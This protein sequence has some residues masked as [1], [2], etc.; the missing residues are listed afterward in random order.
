M[1]IFN[2]IILLI[3][4]VNVYAS[5][6]NKTPKEII[7]V[8]AGAAD[9][10]Y[11]HKNECIPKMKNDDNNDN[12]NLDPI[13]IN[14]GDIGYS[15]IKG[16]IY[17]IIPELRKLNKEDAKDFFSKELFPIIKKLL[18][19]NGIE[20][21]NNINE[22]T[23]KL[24]KS[25]IN[26]YL[27]EKDIIRELLSS[28]NDLITPPSLFTDDYIKK[29][30]LY[31]HIKNSDNKNKNQ[32]LKKIIDFVNND[33]SKF[34]DI[35]RMKSQYK[36]KNDENTKPEDVIDPEDLEHIFDL[37]KGDKICKKYFENHNNS[38]LQFSIFKSTINNIDRYHLLLNDSKNNKIIHPITIKVSKDNKYL[39]NKKDYDID[40]D[41]FPKEIYFYNPIN[42][43]K[44][45]LNSYVDEVY[46]LLSD[47]E[48]NI[49]NKSL[50]ILNKVVKNLSKGDIPKNVID[51]LDKQLIPV[52]LD[53]YN[54]LDDYF[55][56]STNEQKVRLTRKIIENIKDLFVEEKRKLRFSYHTV[57][58]F[59]ANDIKNKL[60]KIFKDEKNE[61]LIQNSSFDFNLIKRAISDNSNFTLKELEQLESM[62]KIYTKA[63]TDE[64]DNYYKVIF[65][66]LFNYYHLV[67]EEKITLNFKDETGYD[68]LKDYLIKVLNHDYLNTDFI[69]NAF[70]FC[71]NDINKKNIESIHKYFGSK[72]YNII[73]LDNGYLEDNS[74]EILIKSGSVLRDMNEYSKIFI[75]QVKDIDLGDYIKE[76]EIKGYQYIDRDKNDISVNKVNNNGVGKYLL[77]QDS[78]GNNVLE[79]IIDI[80]TDDQKNTNLPSQLEELYN[81][82]IKDNTIQNNDDNNNDDNNNNYDSNNNDNG[83]K[84]KIDDADDDDD[85]SD[86]GKKRKIG[87][88]NN[89]DNDSSNNDNIRKRKIHD[90]KN[91]NHWIDDILQY[92]IVDIFNNAYGNYLNI[93]KIK[94]QLNTYDDPTENINIEELAEEIANNFVVQ[95]NYFPDDV[96]IKKGI[97]LKNDPDNFNYVNLKKNI[98]DYLK[99]QDYEKIN[100]IKLLLD[101]AITQSFS[102]CIKANK[103]INYFKDINDD[104]DEDEELSLKKQ[105][106]Y[107]N[108][109][110]TKSEILDLKKIKDNYNHD[111]INFF[112]NIVNNNLGSHFYNLNTLTKN[113]YNRDITGNDINK[114]VF[115]NTGIFIVG[116]NIFEMYF[117]TNKDSTINGL[118]ADI[119]HVAYIDGKLKTLEV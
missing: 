63:N 84:R 16:T 61:Y 92:S 45:E 40:Y 7:A 78:D 108:N 87:D 66:D 49:I 98:I 31:P 77:G 52:H 83:K 102:T 101:N 103:I 75:P 74:L 64:L 90:F 18:K 119:N 22:D 36:N 28:N 17:D 82:L 27:K 94:S 3:Y 110:N 69:G 20:S 104:D 59:N 112:S 9:E 38:S 43:N 95:Y 2:F 116:S 79:H 109:P 111:H 58:T 73:D 70:S 19:N 71:S 10:R 99:N 30:Y 47:T 29:L 48:N 4:F 33:K 85:N 42:L 34:P 54:Q 60:E 86:N 56:D 76:Y 14:I 80:I 62:I 93:K 1:N 97:N 35:S 68:I 44:K 25:Q 81:Y 107:I 53:I 15:K 11:V 41:F 5:S 105:H 91:K 8:V 39:T 106:E 32:L 51:E 88:N 113:F 37:C 6:Q 23:A 26:N 12:N 118:D 114:M 46:S 55:K 100:K 65:N 115:V 72:Y 13:E 21:Y 96:Y 89:G 67:I 57:S 117:S 24:I 50:D